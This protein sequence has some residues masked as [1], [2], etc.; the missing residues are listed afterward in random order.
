M[1]QI[2]KRF[3]KFTEVYP[4]IAK[5]YEELGNEVYAAGPLNIKSRAVI[6]LTISIGQD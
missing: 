2:P 3:M 6:K 5:T 1:L 4:H